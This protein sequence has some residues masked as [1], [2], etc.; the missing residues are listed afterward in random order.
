MPRQ[1]IYSDPDDLRRDIGD[2][3]SWSEENNIPPSDY[4]LS[5][6]LN[7]S[8]SSIN[9]YMNSNSESY[10]RYSPVFDLLKKYREDFYLRQMLAAKNPAAAMFAL[11]QPSNGG[12][13]D[14]QDVRTDTT[15]KIQFT[16]GAESFK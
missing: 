4:R 16:G 13:T 7:M 5:K 6:Y 3:I 14:R 12:W 9:R 8:I 2:F 11:K 1:K 15:V 10:K